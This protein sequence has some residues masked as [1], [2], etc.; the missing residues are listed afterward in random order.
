M[1]EG[2]AAVIASS[3]MS[4]M[5]RHRF[6]NIPVLDTA[7]HR[8]SNILVQDT[9]RHRNSN[10]LVQEM[11][12]HRNSNILVLDTAIH[13]RMELLCPV[14]FLLLHLRPATRAT[15]IIIS[16]HRSLPLFKGQGW[17]SSLISC[18]KT[19]TSSTTMTPLLRLQY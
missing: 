1:Y 4:A 14:G 2:E 3:I 15:L 19:T 13:R 12:R 10:I 5:P 16:F 8:N 17:C 6:S 18:R 11:A 9:A 7:R